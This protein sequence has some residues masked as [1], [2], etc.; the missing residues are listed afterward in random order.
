VTGQG[1]RVAEIACVL[2]VYTFTALPALA[3]PATTGAL[4]EGFRTPRALPLTASDE[5]GLWDMSDRAERAAKAS[6]ERDLDPALTAY[7]Q[8]LVRKLAPEYVDDLRIYVMDRPFFNASAAPNGYVEVFTGLMLRAENEDQ[9]AF[10]LSHEI[11]HFARSHSL[12]SWRR[13]KDAANSAMILSTGVMIAAQVA[14]YSAASSGSAGASNSINSISTAAR[15]VNSLIYLGALAST[16]AFNRDEETEADRMGYVRATGAGYRGS[17]AVDMWSKVLEEAKASQFETVRKHQV[18]GSIF[19]S[20]PL[21]ADRIAALRTMGPGDVTED[22]AAAVRYRAIIR[23]YLA[24]WL[25]DDLRRRDFGE[26]L[27]LLQR[28]EAEGEDLGLVG[29]FRGEAYRL[30]RQPEDLTLSVKSYEDASRH[31]DAPV[32]VWRELGYARNKAGDN[33]GALAALT[34]YLDQA[35]QAQDRWLVE[36]TLKSLKQGAGT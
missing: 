14:S 29:Y 16:F 4:Q 15:E 7:V 21:T 10:V 22:H 30:R 23:P 6:G 27:Y 5:A 18:Q 36:N 19:D 24:R 31:A 33:P 9:L 12:K 2:A 3:N 1:R 25:R 17:A 26:T 11:T 34:T 8:G 13:T 28:L 35:P 32:D 20:H